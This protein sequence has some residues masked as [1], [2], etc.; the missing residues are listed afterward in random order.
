[1]S[2]RS[3]SEY[4]VGKG[5]ASIKICSTQPEI[6]D[7]RVVRTVPT[8]NQPGTKKVATSA[9]KEKGDPGRTKESRG[10]NA[11]AHR[12][13]FQLLPPLQVSLFLML[14]LAGQGIR[15]RIL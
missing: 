1:M 8:K 10:V 12:Y 11:S 3:P 4:F 13:Y 9:D 6:A 14:L 5:S 15:Y 7:D 2:A